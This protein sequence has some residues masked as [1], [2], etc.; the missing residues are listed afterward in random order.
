[1]ESFRLFDLPPEL[2]VAIF[3]AIVF[4]RPWNR[5]VRLRTVNRQYSAFISISN[6]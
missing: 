3:E 1:M 2:V 4:T 6:I 5:I